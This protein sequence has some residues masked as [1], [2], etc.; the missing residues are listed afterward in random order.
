MGKL[1]WTAWPGIEDFSE[2]MDRLVD[3]LQIGR[4]HV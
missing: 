1:N 3:E 2:T 4:A